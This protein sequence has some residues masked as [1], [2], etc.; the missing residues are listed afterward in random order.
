VFDNDVLEIEKLLT[1]KLNITAGVIEGN[2]E[3]AGDLFINELLSG[4][5]EAAGPSRGRGP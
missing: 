4:N 3:I 1:T 2:L 5:N